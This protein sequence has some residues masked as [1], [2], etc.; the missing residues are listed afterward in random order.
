MK[1]LH[2]NCLVQKNDIENGSSKFSE[3]LNLLNDVVSKN[4]YEQPESFLHLPLDQEIRQKIQEIKNEKITSE[5]KYIIVI[6][7]GG[8]SL[9]AKAIYDALLGYDDSFSDKSP[10]MI[11]VDTDNPDFLF[12]VKNLLSSISNSEQVIINIITKSGDTMETVVNSEVLLEGAFTG[13]ESRIIVTTN[14]GSKLEQASKEK[15]ISVFNIPEKVGG[16]FSVFS[17]A[18]MLPLALCGIDINKIAEG[19][20]SANN[21]YL[22]ESSENLAILS[23]IIEYSHYKAGKNIWDHFFFNSQLES[24]GKW[25]RQLIA[26]S[27]GKEGQGPTPTVSIGTNDLHSMVQLYLGGPKDKNTT[28]IFSEKNKNDELVP[29]SFPK[30]IEGVSGKEVSELAKIVFE[31]VKKTYFESGLPYSEIVLDGISEFSIGEFMQF[32]MIE[33]LCLAKLMN[34]NPF[35]Q[36]NVELYKN[37]VRE[38]LSN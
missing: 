9:G 19:A 1:F 11:F 28:F 25:C 22:K 2:E 8:S 32:K 20:V 26:E 6:G 33:V 4:S 27:L 21:E 3:Y 30:V 23:A 17:F 38:A 18:G 34:V 29:D 36:P 35:G 16:R 31:G 7:I 10:K 13:M 14:A 37:N 24:L 15:G 5:L 12:E